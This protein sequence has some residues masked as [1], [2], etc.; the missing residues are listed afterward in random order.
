MKVN[1]RKIPFIIIHGLLV[2]GLS[3]ITVS[4]LIRQAI[5]TYFNTRPLADAM[6]PLPMVPTLLHIILSFVGMVPSLYLPDT[7]RNEIERR[8]LPP[9]FITITIIDISV[10]ATFMFLTGAGS[11]GFTAIGRIHLFSI[12]FSSTILLL[13]G[14]FHIGINTGKLLQFT[15]LSASGCLLIASLVPLSVAMYPMETSKWYAD[16]QFLWVPAIMGV[17]SIVNY[18]SLYLREQ[19]QHNLFRSVSFT[20]IIVGNI[21]YLTTLNAFFLWLGIALYGIGIFVGIPRGRFSQ[22]E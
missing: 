7:S 15:L 6:P 10:V 3:G 12:L 17:V 11:I 9:L 2:L 21:L 1:H 16:R 18:I 8:L 14:L 22:L 20:C 5:P 4:I 19:T 13:I